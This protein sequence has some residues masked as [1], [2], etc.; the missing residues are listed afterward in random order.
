MYS[1]AHSLISSL[2]RLLWRPLVLYPGVHPS[3]KSFSQQ[4][5]FLM[6]CPGQ[7]PSFHLFFFQY[8][9]ICSVFCPRYST[10]SSRL[11]NH[12]S[13][14][15]VLYFSSFLCI[16]HPSLPYVVIDQTM[17]SSITVALLL[18]WYPY[19]SILLLMTSLLNDPL[20]VSSEDPVNS[21]LSSVNIAR[22][23]TK[24]GTCYKASSFTVIDTLSL[25]LD[26]TI[27]LV[28]AVLITRLANRTRSTS[29]CRSFTDVAIRAYSKRA[30]QP[31]CAIQDAI[32]AVQ[33]EKLCSPSWRPHCAVF[34]E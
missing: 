19:S 3:L 15:S 17:P 8:P 20:P 32:C 5:V 27:T 10:L 11:Q 34:Q 31:I 25:I 18:R 30:V 1:P 29:S 9:F 6:M 2:Q 24:G 13:K 33:N 23:Y 16:V 14:A 21:W 4:S 28:F 7:F 22:R 12:I 26:E